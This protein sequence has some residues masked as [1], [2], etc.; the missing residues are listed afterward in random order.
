[1]HLK[2]YAATVD[3]EKKGKDTWQTTAWA[4]ES[5]LLKQRIDPVIVENISD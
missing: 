4:R 3:P 5:G 2:R 1:V